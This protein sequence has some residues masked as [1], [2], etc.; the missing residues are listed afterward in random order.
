MSNGGD[1]RT[2]GAKRTIKV[3]DDAPQG[4][5]HRHYNPYTAFHLHNFFAD[6][7][8][9]RFKYKTYGHPI[10]RADVLP[11]DR[12]HPDLKLMVR[13]ARDEPD[14]PGAEFR[15][16]EGGFEGLDPFTPLYFRDAEYRRRR[17]GGLRAMLAADGRGAPVGAA[18]GNETRGNVS[19]SG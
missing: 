13:C 18:D 15:R 17:H 2:V 6:E 14:P 3:Q 16:A 5:T 1:F 19:G 12:I 10:K 4:Q 9:I 8:A 11:L 7:A